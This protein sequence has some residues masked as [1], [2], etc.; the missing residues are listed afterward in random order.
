MEP[1]TRYTT[2]EVA[3]TVPAP[4]GVDGARVLVTL[5]QGCRRL[6][7]ESTDVTYDAESGSAEVKVSLTQEQTAT[8]R[9]GRTLKAQVNWVTQDGKRVA[10][11]TQEAFV[12]E[13]LLDE[14]VDY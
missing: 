5:S 3:V 8:F 2:P 4:D 11:A 1:I 9:S 6:T 14:R 7:V 12:A 10:S 13:N